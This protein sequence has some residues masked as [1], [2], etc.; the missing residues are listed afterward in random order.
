MNASLEVGKKAK[1]LTSKPTAEIFRLL[2]LFSI[3][4]LE[5]LFINL[6]VLLQRIFRPR[7]SGLN[8]FSGRKIKFGV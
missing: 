3:L 8:K 7:F 5:N 1:S 2:D 4:V 6:K